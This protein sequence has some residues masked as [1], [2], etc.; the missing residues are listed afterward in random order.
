M[1]TYIGQRRSV[2]IQQKLEAVEAFNELKRHKEERSLLFREM[3]NWLN[4][5]HSV[6]IPSLS[7]GIQG[8]YVHLSLVMTRFSNKIHFIKL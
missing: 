7:R 4:Y 1:C 8:T 5:Y 2:E 3:K 6:I